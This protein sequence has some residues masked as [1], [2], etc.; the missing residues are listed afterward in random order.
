MQAMRP[1]WACCEA[2]FWVLGVGNVKKCC[3]IN[4]VCVIQTRP[5]RRLLM[6]IDGS[7]SLNSDSEHRPTCNAQ[8]KATRR[9][10]HHFSVRLFHDQ[11]STATDSDW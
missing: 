1:R 4:N 9:P 3:S 2:L 7:Y 6:V 8:L 5:A 10:R 11:S